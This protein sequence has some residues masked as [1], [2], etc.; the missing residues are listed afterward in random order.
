MKALSASLGVAQR[1]GSEVC[2]KLGNKNG[3]QEFYAKEELPGVC[4]GQAVWG[5][6]AQV[7]PRTAAAFPQACAVPLPGY[8]FLTLFNVL[9][10]IME[11]TAGTLE[12]TL[13]F[14]GLAQCLFWR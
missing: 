13:A 5:K 3:I 2:R 14:S 7:L 9:L 6:K 12:R 1:P 11:G 8:C 4:M 10:H